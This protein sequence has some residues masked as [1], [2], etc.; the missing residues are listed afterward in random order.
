MK[1]DLVKMRTRKSSKYDVNLKN[2]LF[3]ESA[4]LREALKI[5]TSAIPRSVEFSE[6]FAEHMDSLF[7][8]GDSFFHIE[9]QTK[10]STAMG[11]RM[12]DYLLKISAQY[13][14]RNLH[15]AQNV[16]QLVL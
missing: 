10:A 3:N 8:S 4:T 1:Y 16:K 9:I 13:G 5:P 2:S 14:Q 6:I 7:Q 15:S 11:W 12:L